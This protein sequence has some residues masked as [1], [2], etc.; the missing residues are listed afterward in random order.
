MDCE[1]DGNQDAKN[2]EKFI[3]SSWGCV[4]VCANR[5][6]KKNEASRFCFMTIYD[7]F[8]FFSGYS[9]FKHKRNEYLCIPL[10]NCS[11]LFVCF[12]IHCLSVRAV[13]RYKTVAYRMKTSFYSW[14]NIPYIFFI[15]LFK[16]IQV[17]N[18]IFIF[19]WASNHDFAQGERE[20]NKKDALE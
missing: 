5:K 18:L 17:T 12:S 20:K 10:L 19:W 15:T 11:Q 9:Q 4:C 14:N 8:H 1:Y 3:F 13:Q 16:R 6:R 2:G 7:E